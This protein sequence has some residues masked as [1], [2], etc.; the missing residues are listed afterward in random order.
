MKRSDA[1]VRAMQLVYEWEMGGDG[2]EDTKLGM[3]EI[4]PD[5][6][7]AGYVDQLVEGVKNNV[8]A[9]DEKIAKYAIGWTIDRITRV[10][11]SI[12]R[13][14]AYE[15][16]YENLPHGIGIN[17]AV[18]IANTFSTEKAGTFINGVLGSIMRGEKA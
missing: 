14:A 11:L 6:S 7:E 2:G 3:L 5:E 1:R 12:L 10:D 4:Q 13:V 9:I 17:E 8:Q 16:L 15:M 18:E